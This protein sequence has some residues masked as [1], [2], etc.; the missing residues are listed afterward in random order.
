MGIKLWGL[1]GA[2]RMIYSMDEL[3]KLFS[4]HEALASYVYVYTWIP[5]LK[6]APWFPFAMVA[7]NNKFDNGWVM[8]RWRLMHVSCAKYMLKLA[9][10]VSDGDSRLRKCDFRINFLTNSQS[11]PLNWYKDH[12]FLKHSLLMLS[13]PETIEGLSIFGHQDY[14]HLAWRLRVQLL[15]PKKEWQIGPGLRVGWSHLDGLVDAAGDKML[16]AKDL[17]PHNKQ[18]WAGVVKMFSTK[19]SEAH[20]TLRHI[21]HITSHHMTSHHIT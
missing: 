19:V 9:G 3:K 2:P 14:M 18:H 1:D 11:D 13:V 5:I 16:N 6:N 8:K 15:N 17:D 12:Y 21:T 10:H 20:L 4:D 7:T